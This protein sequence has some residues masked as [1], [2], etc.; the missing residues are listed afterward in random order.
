MPRT[1]PYALFRR[2]D[3]WRA[4]SRHPAHLL[5]EQGRGHRTQHPREDSCCWAGDKAGYEASFRDSSYS[6]LDLFETRLH[7][8][9]SW[10]FEARVRGVLFLVWL[11]CDDGFVGTLIVLYFCNS[12]GFVEACSEYFSAFLIF[13]SVIYFWE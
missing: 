8:S 10:I 12:V 2:Q 13:F 6:L 7:E 3:P 1:F 9:F 11:R 5:G 4:R